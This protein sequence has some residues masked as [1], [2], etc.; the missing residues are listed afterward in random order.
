[1][2]SGTREL[3]GSE[4]VDISRKISG[5][6]VNSGVNPV[7]ILNSFDI[8]PGLFNLYAPANDL[9]YQVV[10]AFYAGRSG[11][12]GYRADAVGRLVNAVA[13]EL[14]GNAELNQLAHDLGQSLHNETG[15]KRAIFLSY[16]IQDRQAVD[17]LYDALQSKDPSLAL[18]QD[19][20]SIPLGKDWLDVIRT[21]AGSS[22]IMTCW[23]TTNYLK[24]TF[25]H[26]EIGIAQ[27][28]G[29]RAIPIM[30]DDSILPST[31]SYLAR[32]QT[33]F[34]PEPIDYHFVAQQLINEL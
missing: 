15:G 28:L 29:A 23:L 34:P 12:A 24:S 8:T 33:L 13:N 14:Q 32:I 16:S 31:P 5:Y 7:P 10:Q 20:R 9:W 6:A 25:C 17:E 21:Q 1:M 26:Y 18:F 2:P 30:L 4:L 22:S 11:K 27:S 3:T 19:H